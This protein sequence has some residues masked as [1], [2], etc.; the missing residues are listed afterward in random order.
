[1]TC[2]RGVSESSL[3]TNKA[4]KHSNRLAWMAAVSS[5]CFMD[6]AREVDMTTT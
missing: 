6:V 3:G 4:G 1:M 5:M 2:L